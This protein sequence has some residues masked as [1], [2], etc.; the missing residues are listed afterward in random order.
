MNYWLMK[1]EPEDYSIDD[2][3][4]EKKTLWSGIRNYQARNF[5]TKEMK[6]GDMVIFYHSNATPPGIAG[7]ATVTSDKAVADPLQFDKKS[8]YFEPRASKDK[9]V[10]ECVELG[11]KEKFKTFVSLPELKEEKSLS[12]MRLLQ[13]GNRLSILPLQKSEFTKLCKLAGSTII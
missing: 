11:F 1:S 7:L 6:K 3:K 9:I 4:K 8:K 2:L 13:K 10:W 12:E 5:M